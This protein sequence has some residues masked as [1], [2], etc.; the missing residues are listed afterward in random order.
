[1]P[2]PGSECQEWPERPR[3]AVC[4][5]AMK[6]TPS[7]TGSVG[8]DRA[9]SSAS[10]F[11]ESVRR[12]QWML[13]EKIV[14][15][16]S[17]AMFSGVRGSQ[18]ITELFSS[19]RRR[20]RRPGLHVQF[21]LNVVGYNYS[22]AIERAAPGNSVVHAV[23]GEA[24]VGAQNLAARRAQRAVE[25]EWQVHVFGDAADGQRAVGNIAVTLLFHCLAL[26]GDFG[27]L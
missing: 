6:A 3:P 24:G 11:V 14:F 5:S 19:G 23:D 4:S 26:E 27:E 15:R 13:P 16:T 21:N 17:G 9:A 10:E 2:V 18:L 25:R 7:G 20:G 8:H 1:M 12:Q 22:A